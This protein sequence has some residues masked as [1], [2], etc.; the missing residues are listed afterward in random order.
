M[1]PV[2][3]GKSPISVD[4]SDY[5]KAK[6][7]LI[8]RIGRYC[9]FCERPILTNLAVED[10]QPK[11]LASHAHLIGRWTNFLLAC[12]NCNST[13]GKKDV[14]LS[15]ILLPD[16]DNTFAAFIYTADG[17]IEPSNLAVNNGLTKVA[18]DTLALTGLDKKISVALDENGKEV[19]ID[20]VSQRKQAWLTAQRAKGHIVKQP[21]NDILKEQVTETA[22][23]SGF[24]S[25]WM[26]VF[27][28]DAD[29]RNRLIDGFSG[30]RNSGCFDTITTAPISPA[31]NPDSLPNGG[32]L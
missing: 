9:S 24:F 32:K 2:K 12:V 29:M 5:E 1:R 21:N 16:R 10:I 7:Y 19:A 4:F 28:N 8:S 6:P 25:I 15:N 27:E 26:T 3:R 23:Q 22:K 20:R 30:T 14:T 11:G 17:R 13:K 31:P 18:Q